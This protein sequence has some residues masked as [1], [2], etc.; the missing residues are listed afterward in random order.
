MKTIRNLYRRLKVYLHDLRVRR[1]QR[2]LAEL[3]RRYEQSA[4]YLNALKHYR[5]H[6]EDS[7]NDHK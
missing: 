1:Y 6:L 2:R 4:R 5:Q 7:N 3:T